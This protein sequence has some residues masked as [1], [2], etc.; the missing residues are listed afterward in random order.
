VRS[1]RRLEAETRRNIEVIWLLRHLKSDFR[2]IT[3]FR[4]VNRSAFGVQ[5]LIAAVR[6]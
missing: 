2:T 5:G 1:S 6:S 3:D 4:R